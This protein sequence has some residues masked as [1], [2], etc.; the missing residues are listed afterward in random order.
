MKRKDWRPY[1]PCE[2]LTHADA[3]SIS[4]LLSYQK[5]SD[6]V[7]AQVRGVVVRLIKR[8]PILASLSF[9]F[10][11]FGDSLYSRNNFHAL[12]D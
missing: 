11:P 1:F 3:L 5:Q 8:D 7:W 10:L 6:Q 4:E 9:F 2:S 12:L